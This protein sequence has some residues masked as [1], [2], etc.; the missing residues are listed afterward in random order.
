MVFSV[1]LI[2]SCGTADTSWII[3]NRHEGLY[4]VS[5][6]APFQ[7]YASETNPKGVT[8]TLRNLKEANEYFDR[9]FSENLSFEVLFVDTAQWNTYA[10]SPPPGMPQ[11]YYD[12]T[13]VL[14]LDPS[15][16]SVR[17]MNTIRQF[18]EDKKDS[19]YKYFGNPLNLDL[20]FREGL[21]L[22]ELGHLYQ[23]YR[24]GSEFQRRWLNE[25]FGNIC[26]VA[27]SK[28]ISDEDVFLRMTT[29]Q[30]FLDS[31]NLWGSVDCKTLTEF[32]D[33]YFELLKKGQNYGWYQT[34][35]FFT[36]S[37]LYKA[38]GDSFLNDFRDF[39]ISTQPSKTGR[40][41]DDELI[42]RMKSAFGEEIV[43]RMMKSLP[44]LQ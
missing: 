30:K 1:L 18:S 11:A 42:K 27:A 36:A 31:E 29:F 44:T 41:E 22:H 28:N 5:F 7:I 9:V 43:Q 19:L 8:P 15:V 25:L 12:G 4:P 32:E 10:F 35:F 33:K 24:T 17:Y 23:F 2:V 20:F 39:L 6:S 16:M 38:Y 21:V 26:Q 40:L 14:G 34:R 13:I 37:E 3:K